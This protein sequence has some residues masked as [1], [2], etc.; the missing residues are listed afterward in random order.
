[1]LADHG[2]MKALLF[3]LAVVAGCT[4]PRAVLAPPAACILSPVMSPPADTLR[5]FFD[6]PLPFF[7]DH[8]DAPVLFRQAENTLITV[9]CLGVVR[10][11]LATKWGREDE[12]RDW[13]FKLRDRLRDGTPISARSIVD[14][15]R[16]APEGFA[17]IDSVAVEGKHAIRIFFKNAQPAIPRWLGTVKVRASSTSAVNADPVLFPVHL[18]GRDVRDLLGENVDVMV[19][20]DPDVIA[21]ARVLSQMSVHALPWDRTYVLAAR[22]SRLDTARIE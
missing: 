9:D 6:D 13:T 21:Y 17:G 15:W 12:G 2:G 10:A 18:R 22:S 8:A 14:Y 7:T 11:G 16:R 4:A 3:C 20:R 1:M 5:T 19:T